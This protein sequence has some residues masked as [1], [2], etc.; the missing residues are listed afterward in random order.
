MNRA[1]LENRLAAA[2]RHLAEAERHVA[3]QRELGRATRHPAP[4]LYTR[5]TYTTRASWIYCAAALMALFGSVS[6]SS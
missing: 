1:M 6:S 2:E 4:L 3:H 5:R